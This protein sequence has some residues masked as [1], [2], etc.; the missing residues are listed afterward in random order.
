MLTYF[1]RLLANVISA[2]QVLLFEILYRLRRQDVAQEMES[3]IQEPRRARPGTQ[4][5]CC[6]FSL[7]FLCDILPSRN[8]LLAP[9]MLI[10]QGPQDPDVT[11]V[12]TYM[13]IHFWHPTYL[14]HRLRFQAH[15]FC[16]TSMMYYILFCVQNSFLCTYIPLKSGISFRLYQTILESWTKK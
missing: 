4:L 2:C 11:I 1:L 16:V 13:K 8:L 3:S 9:K 12:K 6:L 5:G 7:H 10:K 14:W 15:I